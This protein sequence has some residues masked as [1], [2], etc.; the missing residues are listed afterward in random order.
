MNYS[1]F[2]TSNE[3]NIM[4]NEAFHININTKTQRYRDFSFPLCHCNCVGKSQFQFKFH[5][6]FFLVMFPESFPFLHQDILCC[7]W[8]E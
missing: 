7:L 1:F 5:L 4:Q 8:V 3:L 6:P 2:I